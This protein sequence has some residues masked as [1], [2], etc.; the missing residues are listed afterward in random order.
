MNTSP[1]TREAAFPF[2]GLVGLGMEPRK[3]KGLGSLDSA[4]AG[5]GGT[6]VSAINNCTKFATLAINAGVQPTAATYV[7]EWSAAQIINLMTEYSSS[8][9]G[10]SGGFLTGAIPEVRFSTVVGS[11]V[12][13]FRLLP[14]GTALQLQICTAFSA[15]PT[16][17]APPPVSGG[18]TAVLFIPGATPISDPGTC[19]NWV[20]F[21]PTD[22]T[23]VTTSGGMTES[24]ADIQLN[25]FISAGAPN[26]VHFVYGG[27]PYKYVSSGAEGTNY[28]AVCVDGAMV[29]GGQPGTPTF[30]NYAWT[31][32]GAQPAAVAPPGQTGGEW[33]SID[34]G[35]TWIWYPEPSDGVVVVDGA[36]YV[37][38]WPAEVYG[39]AAPT[40]VPDSSGSVWTQIYPDYWVWIL[41]AGTLT[42][43]DDVLL[44]LAGVAAVGVL[45]Y[46]LLA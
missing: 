32:I 43:T 33:D 11:T 36:Y 10:S 12:K 9:S 21:A 26:G 4:I 20:K 30:Q 42:E 23:N 22:E 38:N 29:A 44:V 41:P 37:I 8:S 17:P 1:V 16:P 18:G 40:A 45:G 35:T 25:N 5:L 34:G 15:A 14:V 31:I 7:P 39:G 27:W 24:Q 3:A 2:A 6:I 13:Y 28:I 46:I 19:N